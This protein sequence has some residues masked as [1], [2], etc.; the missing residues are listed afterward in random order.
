[1]FHQSIIQILS[2]FFP[3]KGKFSKFCNFFPERGKSSKFCH[4]FFSRNRKS[5]QIVSY[6]SSRK[7]KII[8]IVSCFFHK[9]E[10]HTNCVMFFSIK[11]K[12]LKIVSCFFQLKENPSCKI[13]GRGS[14][15]RP[16]GASMAVTLTC[17][18]LILYLSGNHNP[19]NPLFV[20][21]SQSL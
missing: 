9:K 12:I 19:S 20:R 4:V 13:R 14:N 8:Q 5:I 6:F 17:A 18:L 10:N 16:P 1:M 7:R 21:Y 2:C 15:N 11:R 3:E